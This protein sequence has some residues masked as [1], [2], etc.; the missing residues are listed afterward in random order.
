MAHEK[1]QLKKTMDQVDLVL[2]VIQAVFQTVIVG[3]VEEVWSQ[4]QPLVVEEVEMEEEDTFSPFPARI[5][6]WCSK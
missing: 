5:F 6:E 1:Q 4:Q 3:G 2:L